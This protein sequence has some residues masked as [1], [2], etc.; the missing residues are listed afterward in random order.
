[1][2]PICFSRT[3]S[4]MFCQVSPVP[5]KPHDL[6]CLVFVMSKR[7]NDFNV[8]SSSFDFSFCRVLYNTIHLWLIML[9]AWSICFTRFHF[10]FAP[11][12][13]YCFH[14]LSDSCCFHDDAK[15]EQY[16]LSR[17]LTGNPISKRAVGVLY[18]GYCGPLGMA[19]YPGHVLLHQ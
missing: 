5:M 1:V 17:F 13:N 11:S 14:T 15:F 9:I 6:C 12:I 18:P 2:V 3:L 8:L 19:Q 10:L 4:L 16:G 7:L